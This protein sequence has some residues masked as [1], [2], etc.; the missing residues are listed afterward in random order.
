MLFGFSF[1]NVVKCLGK[2]LDI[3]I[4]CIDF[5]IMN[6]I[7]EYLWLVCDIIWFMWKFKIL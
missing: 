7:F 2:W 5:L 3:M 4:D 1:C 6:N